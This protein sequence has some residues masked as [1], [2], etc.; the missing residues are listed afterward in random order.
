MDKQISICLHAQEGLEYIVEIDPPKMAKV[1]TKV[2]TDLPMSMSLSTTLGVI[3]E[4]R[5]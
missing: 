3:C 4:E 2:I 1:I 5:I